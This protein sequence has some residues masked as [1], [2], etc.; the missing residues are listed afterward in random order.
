MDAIHMR[1]AIIHLAPTHAVVEK[2]SPETDILV[3]VSTLAVFV[4]S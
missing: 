3:H 2:G 1:N 4:K